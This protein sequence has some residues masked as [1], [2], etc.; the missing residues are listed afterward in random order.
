MDLPDV[1]SE[2]RTMGVSS[3][4]SITMNRRTFSRAAGLAIAAPAIASAQGA[5]PAAQPASGGIAGMLALA[6]ATYPWVEE[7]A[8][9]MISYAD[10]ATQ[11]EVTGVPAVDS[12]DDPDFSQWVAATRTLA[13]P[14]NAAQYLKFWREDYG[15]DL[16]QA[17][18]TLELSLP[19][20]N[21]SLFRGRFDHETIRA[22]LTANGYREVEAGGHEILTLRDDYEQ[23]LTSPFAYKLAAMNHVALL[24]DGT[25]ACSSVQ[26]A[27]VAVLDVANGQAASLMEQAG[28]AQMADQVPADLVS[29]MIVSGTML[30]GNIPPGLLDLEPGATPDFDAIATE[31]AATSEMPPVVMLLIGS[32]AGGP[33]FGEDIETPA[34]VPDARAVAVALFLTPEMAEAAVPV[35]EERLATGASAATA[36]PFSE[37]FP[38]HDVRAVPS[39]P[40][41]VIDLTLGSETRPDILVNMLLNRDLNFLAW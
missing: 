11:L 5:T 27:L 29:A 1:V 21:L 15:F 13:V 33:L 30:A 37:F 14:Q 38:E 35:I 32:T 18:E 3:V 41:L 12:M 4:R 16:F 24:D 6:P 20:F 17:D 2:I 34:G 39:A 19:P 10:L 9:L 40:V 8:S 26:A 36:Q 7:P 22:T 31:I 23:D 25:I 28:I